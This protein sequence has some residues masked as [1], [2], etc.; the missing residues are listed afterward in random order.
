MSTKEL[1]Q[2]INLVFRKAKVVTSFLNEDHI[3]FILYEHDS[4]D[5]LIW[6]P[7]SMGMCVNFPLPMPKEKFIN[8]FSILPLENRLCYVI[9]NF[10]E[11]QFIDINAEKSLQLQLTINSK[12]NGLHQ[13]RYN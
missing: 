10:I 7:T 11:T 3:E 12:Q 13:K 6:L 2:K 4:K 5:Q 1:S 9:N 8:E